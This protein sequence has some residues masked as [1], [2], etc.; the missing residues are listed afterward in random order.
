MIQSLL[1]GE[2]VRL[3]VLDLDRDAESIAGW[4]S[5]PEFW[6]LYDRDVPRPLS[7]GQV[8]KKYSLDPKIESMHFPFALRTIQDDRMLGLAGFQWV[9]WSNSNAWLNV[10]IGRAEDRSR[11]FEADTLHVLLTY[12]FH[13]LNLY[14]LQAIA[15]EYALSWRQL[16]EQAGFT[17]EVCRRQ[18]IFHHAR[19]WDVLIYG[20]LAP[21]WKPRQA[22]PGELP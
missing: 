2:K 10:S 17:L 9:D 11:G 15:F 1:Q 7:P 16:L 21:E 4:T 6:N 22:V 8:K 14:R 5:D 18:E 20:L 12:A 19:R 3:A 13:E